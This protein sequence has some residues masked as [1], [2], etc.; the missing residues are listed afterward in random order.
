M[1]NKGPVTFQL[2]DFQDKK[3]L[4][5]CWRSILD[6]GTERE[7]LVFLDKGS[8]SIGRE[9]RSAKVDI[10][11][12]TVGYLNATRNRKTRRTEP[13]NGTD[14]SSQTRQT[15]GVDGYRSGS[16][17][18]ARWGFCFRSVLK[19]NW[20]VY[21]VQTRTAGRLP[22]QVAKTKHILIHD[23]LSPW[24][25]TDVH[26]VLCVSLFSISVTIV[27]EIII[28][29]RMCNG[30]MGQTVVL[31]SKLDRLTIHLPDI[32]LYLKARWEHTLYSVEFT[33]KYNF[34]H[35]CHTWQ[36]RWS[37]CI[38]C[39][40][41]Y[42]HHHVAFI[43]IFSCIAFHSD[44]VHIVKIIKIASGR[45]SRFRRRNWWRTTQAVRLYYWKIRVYI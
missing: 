13:E 12:L 26:I 15:P 30:H 29:L 33:M 40:C 11:R 31:D 39:I 23:H 7:S 38:T 28:R 32:A 34:T 19:P 3:L 21:P 42:D 36:M 14:G 22:G 37:P 44:L 43:H 17:P 35:W 41:M 1:H 2:P 4:T 20:T 10:V 18:P 6:W 45:L 24:N 25:V 8:Q 16:G 5:F 27:W 9:Q